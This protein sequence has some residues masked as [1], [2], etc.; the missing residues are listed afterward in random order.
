ML[1]TPWKCTH[2]LT[3]MPGSL[4]GSCPNK[5]L[6]E[7]SY[8]GDPI[9]FSFSMLELE[10]FLTYHWVVGEGARKLI[11]IVLKFSLKS[12]LF[13]FHMAIRILFS[14]FSFA[15]LLFRVCKCE[16]VNFSRSFSA[17]LNTMPISNFWHVINTLRW[18]TCMHV[19]VA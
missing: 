14:M 1:C 3:A 7:C 11:P 8:S 5:G 6:R 15:F 4:V 18:L 9:G 17:C 12:A 10:Y 16:A 2:C 13:L 19:C